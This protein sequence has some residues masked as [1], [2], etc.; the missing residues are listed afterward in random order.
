MTAVLDA[1]VHVWD[2]AAHPQPWT[3][4]LPL[5]H[6]SFLVEDLRSVLAAHG[7]DGAIVVQA[8]DTTGETL[9]LLALADTEP[10]IAGVVGWADFTAP[11]LPAQLDRLRAAPGGHRLVGLRHQ[12]QVEPDPAGS[13]AIRC[14]SGLSQLGRPGAGL[15]RGGLPATSCRWSIDTVRAVPDDPLRAR[16]RGKAARHRRTATSRPG[17]GDIAALAEAAERRGEAVRAGHR[18]PRGTAG[19][20]SSSIPSSTTCSTA[21]ARTG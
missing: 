12:L 19:P 3:D 2:L 20:R 5:L 1:H 17:D 13:P 14:A 18:G 15:R 8:G 6:R 9:D 21:S 11:D 16:P 10:V 4:S 7:V